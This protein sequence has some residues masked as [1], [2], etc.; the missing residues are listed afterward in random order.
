MADLLPTQGIPPVT[1][2][3][4][5]AGEETRAVAGEP[6]FLPAPAFAGE[7]EIPAHLPAIAPSA[8]RRPWWKMRR[9]RYGFLGVLVLTGVILTL[10]NSGGRNRIIFING[11]DETLPALTVTAA[12]FTCSV[13]PLEARASHRWLVPPGGNGEEI[14]V[15]SATGEE[16]PQWKWTGNPMRPDSGVS[17][18]LR[19]WP[20][21]TVEESRDS[22]IWHELFAN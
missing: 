20:D 8:P 22:S 4:S 19:L 15:L 12:G 18:M 5:A 10:L 1:A 21:G 3:D 2:P 11:S 17:L 6:G 9:V 14:H 16:V 13:P 7:A